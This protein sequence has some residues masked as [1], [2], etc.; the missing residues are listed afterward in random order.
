MKAINKTT[1][2]VLAEDLSVADT[3]LKRLVGLLGKKHL[4]AG[5]GLL[6]TPCKG[7]H[8]IGMRFP[9]DVIFIS[10][11]NTIIGIARNLQPNRITRLYK[12]S[13]RVLEL[14][15]NILDATRTNIGDTIVFV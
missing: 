15:A 13:I 9:I 10:K 2:K 11:N 4:P 1:K 3:A 14:P 5:A 12:Y 6:I 8:T 7:I